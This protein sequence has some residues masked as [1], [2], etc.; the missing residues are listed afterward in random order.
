[1]TAGWIAALTAY[2]GGI[3]YLILNH[4]YEMTA[5]MECPRVVGKEITACEMMAIL[6]NAAIEAK[7]PAATKWTIT[8]LGILGFSTLVIAGIVK[9]AEKRKRP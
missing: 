7:K 9:L 4:Y 1:M 6:H 8:A 2:T 3:G 5:R